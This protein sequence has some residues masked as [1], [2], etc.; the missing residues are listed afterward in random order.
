MFFSVSMF[1]ALIFYFAILF[2]SLVFFLLAVFA[3]TNAAFDA[4]PGGV[5]ALLADKAK[6]KETLLMHVVEGAKNPTRNGYSFTTLCPDASGF[7]EIAVKVTVDTAESFMFGDNKVGAALP[8]GPR[9]QVVCDNG[10]VHVI[11]Q[12]LLPYEGTVAPI[13]N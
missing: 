1:Q 6:L 5:D 9:G 2:I 13:R 10:Y 12:V 8:N 4:I 3:P 7:K 11:D